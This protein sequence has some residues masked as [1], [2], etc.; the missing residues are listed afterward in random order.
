MHYVACKG[1]LRNR[2]GLYKT[3][4]ERAVLVLNDSHV[5]PAINYHPNHNSLGPVTLSSD[6]TDHLHGRR[7]SWCPA[8][9]SFHSAQDF[10]KPLCSSPFSLV[11]EGFAKHGMCAKAKLIARFFYISLRIYKNMIT[12]P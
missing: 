9:H 3:T 4:I 12:T 2:A 6:L 7:V 5:I 11:L 8:A 1:G 10:L